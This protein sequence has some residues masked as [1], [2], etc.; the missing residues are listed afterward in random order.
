[1]GRE[2]SDPDHP[3]GAVDRRRDAHLGRARP[4]LPA[5]GLLHRAAGAARSRH[6]A[7]TRGRWWRRAS[8]TA[9]RCGHDARARANASSAACWARCAAWTRPRCARSTSRSS[10]RRRAR[11]CCATAA[12]STSSTAGPG[13]PPTKTRS[14]RRRPHRPWAASRWCWRSATRPARY[15]AR[16]V[17]IALPRDPTPANVEQAGLALPRRRRADVSGRQRT[18]QRQLGRAPRHGA[19]DRERRWSRRRAPA[20][21]HRRGRARARVDRL[22]RRGAGAGRRRADHD[23][24]DGARRG[25]GHRDPGVARVLLR[26]RHRHAHG[27]GGRARGPRAGQPAAARPAGD[28]ERTRRAAAVDH[29]GR[30]RRRP[31]AQPWRSPV[32]VP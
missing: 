16:R 15:L 19:G 17:A 30:A 25:R 1:M 26:C 2:R 13:S 24:V 9:R 8:R 27:G 7:R 20:R 23:L 11:A 22:A 6:A 5:L 28:R 4:A 29:A 12:A 18:G 31:R 32:T 3:G 14:T 21:R 10:S